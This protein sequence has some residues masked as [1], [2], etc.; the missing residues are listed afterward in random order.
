MIDFV[1]IKR[2]DQRTHLVEYPDLVL[3]CDPVDIIRETHILQD[4]R[5]KGERR[6]CWHFGERIHD[7]FVVK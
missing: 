2:L 7:I 3:E 4:P 1:I 6:F 5:I